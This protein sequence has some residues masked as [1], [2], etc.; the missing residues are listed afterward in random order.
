MQ[1]FLVAEVSSI[2]RDSNP[3]IVHI[4]VVAFAQSDIYHGLGRV[5]SLRKG[6]NSDINLPA[7]GLNPQ[8]ST[9]L[10]S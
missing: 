1:V 3:T 9:G 6:P 7:M 4:S 10:E 5:L 8:P 2:F